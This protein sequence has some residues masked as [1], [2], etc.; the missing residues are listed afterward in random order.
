[1]MEANQ[2]ALIAQRHDQSI[3]VQTVLDVAKRWD[4]DLI[5][6]WKPGNGRIAELPPGAGSQK[7]VGPAPLPVAAAP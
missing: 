2:D 6:V 1:M 7:L 4:G 5:V 3:L